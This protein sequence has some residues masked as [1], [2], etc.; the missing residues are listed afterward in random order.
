MG[1]GEAVGGKEESE[2]F[3]GNLFIKAGTL[4]NRPLFSRSET[5]HH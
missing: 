5:L 3:D 4:M 1:M 2:R